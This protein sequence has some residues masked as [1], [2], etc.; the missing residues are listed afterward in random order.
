M[1]TKL[2]DASFDNC[3]DDEDLTAVYGK[4]S[5]GRVSGAGPAKLGRLRTGRTFSTNVIH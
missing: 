1:H 4:V 3:S 5:H 2:Y